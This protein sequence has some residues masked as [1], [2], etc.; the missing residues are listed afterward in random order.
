[1]KEDMT[2]A[3]VFASE[4]PSLDDHLVLYVNVASGI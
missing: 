2:Q 3:T 1:M 4:E